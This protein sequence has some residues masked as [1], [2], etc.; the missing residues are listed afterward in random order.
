L[1]TL[2]AALTA[3]K[4]TYDHGGNPLDEIRAIAVLSLNLLESKATRRSQP[5]ANGKRY[6][7]YHA[8]QERS[9]PVLPGLFH[10]NV[11]EFQRCW[12]QMISGIRSPENSIALSGMTQSSTAALFV[13]RCIYTAV[14]AFASCYDLWKPKS[15][16]TPGT[17]F[18]LVLGGILSK[19]LPEH[20]RSKYIPLPGNEES[21]STDIVFTSANRH[22]LVFAAKITTRERIV[23][24]FAHQRILDSV[25][26]EDVYRSL[27]LCI[28]ETQRDDD[29]DCVNDICV[30]GTVK[31]FQR[32]LASIDYLCYADPP[33]RYLAADVAEVISVKTIGWLLTEGLKVVAN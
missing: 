6:E 18:E 29:G 26:G 25:F 1:Q 33:A 9:R 23:Q 27:I 14:M 4:R 16:K 17:F 11:E 24:P 12:D 13:N 3:A 10:T 2:S 32:H 28:S 21:V 8:G 19:L 7:V 30:P 5:S 20:S 22:N 15:R 31:L